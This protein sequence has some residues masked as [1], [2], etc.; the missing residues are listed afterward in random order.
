MSVLHVF[1]ILAH[2]KYY[3]TLTSFLQWPKNFAHFN[4]IGVEVPF[5]YKIE[6]DL[7]SHFY[8]RPSL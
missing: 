3:F 6:A 1:Y 8:A 7:H 5:L 2:S 4:K